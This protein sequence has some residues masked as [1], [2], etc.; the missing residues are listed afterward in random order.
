MSSCLIVAGEKSGEEHVLS[1]YD[2]LVQR[3]PQTLFFG[4]GG[5]DLRERGFEAI[6]HTRDFSSMGLSEV[7]GKF[8]FYF[9]AM[10]RLER[11]IERRKTKTVILVDFQDFNLALAKR[12]KKKGVCILYYVAPQAWVW[13]ASR[14]KTLAKTVHTLFSL[15]PFELEW[16]RSRGVKQI[17]VIKHPL[18]EKYE[19]RLKAGQD[20]LNEKFPKGKVR[21]LLLPG[22]RIS[23][24]SF[25]L[26]DFLWAVDHFSKGQNRKVEV[27][28]VKSNNVPCEVFDSFPLPLPPSLS[29][30]RIGRCPRSIGHLPCGQRNRHPLLRSFSI[31]HHCEL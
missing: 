13:R 23:E 14:V 20:L 27:S 22:S 1:F 11:E 3:C 12:L 8:S 5:D 19:K 15:F 31:A 17:K 18:L 4:V 30:E 2:Q 6:Y 26:E 9:K 10:K 21:V 28:I 16:F 25:L 24:V 7:V 29:R